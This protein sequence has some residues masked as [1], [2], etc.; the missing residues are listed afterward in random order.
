MV[1]KTC[2]WNHP[3]LRSVHV[4]TETSVYMQKTKFNIVKTRIVLGIFILTDLEVHMKREREIVFGK[5]REKSISKY[6]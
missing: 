3:S 1:I 2:I 5:E 4:Y 6:N